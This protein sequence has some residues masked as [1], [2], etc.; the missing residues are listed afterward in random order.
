[1][2]LAILLCVA[3]LQVAEC[4]LEG[5]PIYTLVTGWG[6]GN[7]LCSFRLG[8]SCGKVLVKQE[9]VRFVTCHIETIP[10][11]LFEFSAEEPAVQGVFHV[12]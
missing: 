11:I 5:T 10:H 3:G 4:I 12:T 2:A 9:A 7:S 6:R 8:S 1:M